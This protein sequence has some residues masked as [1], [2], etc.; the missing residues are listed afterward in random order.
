METAFRLSSTIIPEVVKGKEFWLLLG[1]NV[2]VTSLRHFGVFE[3]HDYNLHLP[4]GLTGVTGS[5]MTFFVCFY[6]G[7][8]FS[9]YNKIYDLTQAM[10]EQCLELISMLRV[11]VAHVGIQRKA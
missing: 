9:R 10:F 3:P 5:L 8:V 11:Q 7:H 1:F 6:N 2:A 4:F